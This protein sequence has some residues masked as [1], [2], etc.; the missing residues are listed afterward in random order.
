MVPGL[1]RLLPQVQMNGLFP[2]LVN[3]YRRSYYHSADGR[4]R[5]TIDREIQCAAYRS[6]PE[7][8]RSFADNLLVVEL[9]YGPEQEHVLDEFTQY[10]PLRMD[11]FSKYVNGMQLV[12]S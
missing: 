10:W 7:R 6:R 2:S 3:E 1:P 8:L 4:F 9:K 12:N 5:L 11:R